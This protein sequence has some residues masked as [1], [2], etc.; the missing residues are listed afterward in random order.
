MVKSVAMGARDVLAVEMTVNPEVP[1]GAVEM[2]ASP[3]V[4][5]VS[6]KR[7]QN[8]RTS[9]DCREPESWARLTMGRPRVQAVGNL[10]GDHL[11]AELSRQRPVMVM[12]SLKV[13][14]AS[15]PRDVASPV[16]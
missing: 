2:T 1:V 12:R 13:K 14:V 6:E 9:E 11:P 4:Q 15:R 7:G 10:L 16:R 5:Q 8:G 3:E